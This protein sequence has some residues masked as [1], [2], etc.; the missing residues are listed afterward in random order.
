M[1]PASRQII[2]VITGL[3]SAAAGALWACVRGSIQSI[4]SAGPSK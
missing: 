3:G 4:H 1:A 2:I